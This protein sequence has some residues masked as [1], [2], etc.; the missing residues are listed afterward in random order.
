MDHYLS[1]EHRYRLIS[2]GFFQREMLQSYHRH[3]EMILRKGIEKLQ[4]KLS[5]LLPREEV[6]FWIYASSKK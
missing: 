5:T 6:R 4:Q 3:F 1:K 2:H